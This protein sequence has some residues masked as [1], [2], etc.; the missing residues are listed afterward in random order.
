[1]QNPN[2]PIDTNSQEFLHLTNGPW[3][4][5]SLA[6][7][8]AKSLRWFACFLLLLHFAGEH[9]VGEL[10]VQGEGFEFQIDEENDDVDP[11]PPEMGCSPVARIQ[12]VSSSSRALVEMGAGGK[13]LLRRYCRYLI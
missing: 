12:I 10:M 5:T 8:F 13:H 11:K 4:R 3:T 2:G 1:M 9:S 7:Y 6:V